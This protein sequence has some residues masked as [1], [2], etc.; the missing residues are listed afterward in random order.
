M[1]QFLKPRH[2]DTSL[3]NGGVEVGSNSDEAFGAGWRESKAGILQAALQA[4][5]QRRL[6]LGLKTEAKLTTIRRRPIAVSVRGTRN[7][8]RISAIWTAGDDRKPQRRKQIV[9]R[10]CH[11]RH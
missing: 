8:S 4:R 11:W 9:S 5:G 3:I 2:H 6:R 10:F 1:Q 7:G